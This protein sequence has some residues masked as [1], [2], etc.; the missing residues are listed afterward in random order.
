MRR[1]SLGIAPP[2]LAGTAEGR[3]ML[4]A[5]RQLALATFEN[6]PAAIASDFTI[7]NYTETRSLDVATATSTDIANVLA[8]LIRDLQ[9]G[10]AKKG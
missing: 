10:G 2:G 4:G 6:D 1:V 5:V 8:T 3:F 9:R 7:E